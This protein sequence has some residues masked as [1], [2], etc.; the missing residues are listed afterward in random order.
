M[1]FY[2]DSEETTKRRESFE[3]LRD[4]AAAELARCDMVR[5]SPD[6]ANL[7]P[8]NRAIFLGKTKTDARLKSPVGQI[9]DPNEYAIGELVRMFCDSSP[10]AKARGWRADAGEAR[11]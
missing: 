5:C 9:T 11:L 2:Q 8:V 7:H 1:G 10:L 6:P 4:D 3:E